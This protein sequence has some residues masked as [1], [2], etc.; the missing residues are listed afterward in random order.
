M[1]ASFLEKGLFKMFS[2]S[3]KT[4]GIIGGLHAFDEF[5]GCDQSCQQDNLQRSSETDDESIIEYVII[6]FDAKAR[7]GTQNH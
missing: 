7:K 6:I 2:K 3:T 4:L 1:N 5:C